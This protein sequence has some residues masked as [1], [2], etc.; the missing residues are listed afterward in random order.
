MSEQSVIVWD[1]ETVP[2]LVAA[3][4]MLDLPNATDAEVREALGSG[5]P[6]H[7]LHKI[8]CIGA[9]VASRGVEG[10][11]IDALGAPHIGE[12]PEAKL[13]SDFVEK[14]GQLRPLL[15][16]FN[17]H[18]FDL[19]VLRYRAMVNRVS[20]SGLQ[21][22]P[23]FRRYADDALDLCDVLG[24]YVPGSKV[25]LD[26]MSKILGLAGKPKGMDG[27]GVEELVLGGQI[28]EVARYCESDVLN[29]YRVW[30]VYELFCGSISAE[31]LR[32][33]ETQIRDFVASR[34]VVNRHLWPGILTRPLTEHEKLECAFAKEMTKRLRLEED[35][36]ATAAD[37]ANRAL[38][39]G[40]DLQMRYDDPATWAED[41]VV[42]LEFHVNFERLGA[43]NDG[44]G[45][46]AEDLFW[47]MIPHVPRNE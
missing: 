31:E 36:V 19:P 30:L 18:S 34:K 14:I 44:T 17:G 43:P 47:H 4:R 45:E 3:A 33:S 13:I 25:K 37:L 27:S 21:V 16:T 5:F 2:D 8:A 39:N 1:L 23:Y 35:W 20:A 24:S 40:F 7:P 15:V 26:E 9:L 10:W 29:T 28:E 32:W 12:R 41:L 38:E 42:N 6:K 22:R 11:R 46:S